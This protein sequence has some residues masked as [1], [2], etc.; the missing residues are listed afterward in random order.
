MAVCQLA[1]IF[2]LSDSAVLSPM[3]IICSRSMLFLA[4]GSPEERNQ[5]RLLGWV[6]RRW[7]LKA[8]S[9]G[10][11]SLT[12]TM[13]CAWMGN[14][15]GPWRRVSHKTSENTIKKNKYIRSPE[16]ESR[17]SW[18]KLLWIL[19]NFWCRFTFQIFYSHLLSTFFFL[20]WFNNV[21]GHRF[22]WRCLQTWYWH[23]YFVKYTFRYTLD[24]YI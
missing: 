2:I 16:A 17:D 11:F 1:F 4:P 24:L 14:C 8:L 9:I 6:T 19:N 5:C 7:T 21:G 12:S 13:E 3:W 18:K 15:M 20:I 23:L 10:F 22:S